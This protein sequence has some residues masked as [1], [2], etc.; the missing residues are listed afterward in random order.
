MSENYIRI[1]PICD[2]ENAAAATRCSCGASLMGVDFSMKVPQAADVAPAAA[3]PPA[4]PQRDELVLPVKVTEGEGQTVCSHPDCAQSNPTGTLRCLYCNRPL[5][6]TL[7][8]PA[9]SDPT[10]ELQLRLP[11]ELR[12]RYVAR[13]LLPTAGAEADLL[14]VRSQADGADRIV[15]LYR[16]GL[17]GDEAL[18]ARLKLAKDP[19]VIRIDEAGVTGGVR[20]EVMEYLPQGSLRQLLESGPVSVERIR[21]IV[22]EIGEALARVQSMQ[23]LHRDLK[24][25]NVLVRTLTPLSLVLADFGIASVRMGTQHFTGG[26]RTTRYAA[27]EALT[28]V[29]DE[30]A[31]W[32][33]LGM[34]VLEAVVGRHPFEGLN[35]QIVNHQLA[36]KPVDVRTVF[37]DELRKL[38][39][40]LLMRDPRARWSWPEVQ[41]WLAGDPTLMEIQEGAVNSAVRAYRIADSQCTTAVELAVTLVKHWQIGAKDLVRGTV[42]TWLEEQ[43]HDHNLLRKLQDILDVRGVTDDWR[44]LKFVL[45]VVPDIPAV[46]KGTPLTRESLLIAA[47]KASNGD[48]PT[49]AWLQSIH[50]EGVLEALVQAGRAEVS[51]FR[52]QWL[53]GLKRFAE[54]WEKGR[55]AEDRWRREP[56]AWYGSSQ[57]VVDV[58][59]ALYQQS[60]R[61]NQPPVERLHGHVLLAVCLPAFVTMVRS[62]LIGQIADS[63][64]ICPWF[65][66][67]G[68]LHELDTVGVIVAQLLLPLA[69]EDMKQE[70]ERLASAPHQGAT[71]SE[72]GTGQLQHEIKGVV[73]LLRAGLRSQGARLQLRE[74]LEDLQ[75]AGFKVIRLA[76]AEGEAARSRSSL[77]SLMSASIAMQTELD[78]VDAIE[79]IN[80]IWFSPRRLLVGSTLLLGLWSLLPGLYAVALLAVAGAGFAWRHT[81]LQQAK[82]TLDSK[83]KTFARLCERTMGRKVA[84]IKNAA[85]AT[86]APVIPK[87]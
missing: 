69:L 75:N 82:R 15:K 73:E 85:V 8:S 24:P 60:A 39:R 76:P 32:W 46:W 26:A 81:V 28:G 21:E 22:S 47:R 11:A 50:S 19:H 58:H 64:E 3:E 86:N 4:V 74:V 44:L 12:A 29:I 61:M 57:V 14:R 43:L 5:G 42:A 40:G 34:I 6:A 20:F 68:P 38:C 77:D 87:K 63:A 9:R 10:A 31:D 65:E 54:L 62:H 18:L 36:T 35:E 84:S 16:H 49:A 1:C 13:E 52:Q 72:D 41:R 66:S 48:R 79:R 30:R 27:P 56:K 33:S 45:V 53:Q 71:G 67:L 25:E 2:S 80:A 78:R 7:K 59:Y 37:H 51:A 17:E 23:I 70:K 83:A 55:D